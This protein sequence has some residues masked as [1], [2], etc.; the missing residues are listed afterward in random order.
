MVGLTRSQNYKGDHEWCKDG[1][2][3]T[4]LVAKWLKIFEVQRAAEATTA[5]EPEDGNAC[6]STGSSAAIHC[7]LQKTH[8]VIPGISEDQNAGGENLRECITINM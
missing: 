1:K 2:I 3:K 8:P 4:K 5:S 6:L 7:E